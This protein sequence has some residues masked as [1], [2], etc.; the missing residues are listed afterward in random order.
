MIELTRK[1][2][3]LILKAF[4]VLEGALLEQGRSS[5]IL[6]NV[7]YPCELLSKKLGEE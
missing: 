3:L 2:V 4:H 7:D 1:E 5:E 6:E